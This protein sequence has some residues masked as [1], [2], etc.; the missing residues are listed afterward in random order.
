LQE[1]T[2]WFGEWENHTEETKA[3]ALVPVARPEIAFLNYL[4]ELPAMNRQS[5]ESL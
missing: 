1:R 3:E 5:L 4:N 2:E